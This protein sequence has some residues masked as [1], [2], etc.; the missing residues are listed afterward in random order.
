MIN[1]TAVDQAT[2]PD[3]LG[4]QILCSRADKYQVFNESPTNDG[5]TSTGAFGSAFQIC[6]K[7]TPW[8]GGIDA[9]I[10][11]LSPL[12]VCSPQLSAQS[13]S[14][15]VEILQNDITYAAA[16]VA[17]DA[18]GNPSEPVVGLRQTGQDAEL[19]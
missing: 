14:D 9:G 10:E 11:N 16:V 18:S 1:W 12:F 2:V 7:T 5:G 17:I 6:P 13:T 3:L 4:Y 19:L 15:R 8:M